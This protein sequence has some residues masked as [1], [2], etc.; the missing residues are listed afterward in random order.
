MGLAANLAID[1]QAINQAGYLGLSRIAQ[2]FIPQ[3]LEFF[4]T[5]AY[6]FDPKRAQQLLAEAGY[7]NGFDAGELTADVVAG[8]AIGEP[9]VNYLQPVGIRLKLR[10]LERAAFHKEHSEKKLHVPLQRQRGAG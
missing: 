9:V 5:P 7:A 10:P 4:W 8:A 3:G 6:P 2:R 1:R